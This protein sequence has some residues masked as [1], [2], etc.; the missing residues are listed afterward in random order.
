MMNT[1]D[2]VLEIPLATAGLDD[3]DNAAGAVSVAVTVTDPEVVAELQRYPAG[4]ARARFAQTALRI[5]VLCLRQA[6]GEV[7]AAAVKR[8]GDDLLAQ[9]RELLAERGA[10]MTG[11]MMRALARY[12]DPDT[13]LV[14]QRMRALLDEDGELDRVLQ[15]HIGGDESSLAHTLAEHLGASSPLFQMLS[16]DAADG[17][18]ARL[19][20]ATEAAL[21][22]QRAQIVAQFSLDDPASA[23]SRL[24]REV[25]ARQA[26]LGDDVKGQVDVLRKELT[27]DAPDSALSRMHDMLQKTQGQIDRHLTLD[28]DDSALARVRRELVGG[29]E[30][31]QKGNAAF[32]AEV[33]EALAAMQAR[34]A[35]AARG[36]AHGN[37]F[38]AVAGE[39]IAR[40]AGA[41]GDVHEA[42]GAMTGAIR[43]CKVGDHVVTM[44]AD[45]RAPGARIVWEAK[46]KEKVRLGDALDEIERAR[47][48]RGAQI[49]IFV[50][51]AKVAPD[52]VEPLARHGDD[53]VVVW[54]AD[55]PT[56][57]V[58]V[59]AAFSLARGLAMTAAAADEAT[60]SSLREIG[61]A[62]RLIE[63]QLQYLGEMNGWAKTIEGHAAKIAQRTDRMQLELAREIERIDEQVAALGAEGEGA[64]E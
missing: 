4:A 42:T 24:V 26:R 25:E 44:G 46:E 61:Q 39:V 27:L 11:E 57:D 59:S 17:L 13:G 19:A 8:A 34:K 20:Q 30:S 45:S 14:H 53:I 52:G 12:L 63:K 1:A 62:A 21:A 33:R 51:S 49:G 40:L 9:M 50:Y 15:A 2:S 10:E 6:S 47:K 37:E 38:E 32:Q 23:L 54:D 29:I 58:F 18:K 28:D 31:I 41:K 48:N 5:G 60:A 22:D 64:S 43:H 36:T 16:P 55:D 7:D 35:E 3:Q 56:T